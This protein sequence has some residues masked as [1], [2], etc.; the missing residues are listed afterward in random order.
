MPRLP[1]I[2]EPD[3]KKPLCYDPLR[4]RFIYLDDLA[5]R[6]EKVIALD[7]LTQEQ[8]K[9]LVIER[10]KVGPDFQG[11]SISGPPFTRDDVVKA[12]E[13]DTEFGESILTAETTAL[14]ELLQKIEEALQED[15]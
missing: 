10:L 1:N 8:V 14:S 6:K 3:R 4:D 12:I 9:K 7:R 2:P 5:E 13:D 11:T 15:E